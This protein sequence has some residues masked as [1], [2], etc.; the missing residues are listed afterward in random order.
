MGN[1]RSCILA[2]PLPP[3]FLFILVRSLS[4]GLYFLGRENE[5]EKGRECKGKGAM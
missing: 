1:E 4:K 5:K 3:F 2:F